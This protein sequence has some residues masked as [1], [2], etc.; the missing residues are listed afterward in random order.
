MRSPETSGKTS[1]YKSFAILLAQPFYNYHFDE[2]MDF[3]TV[4]NILQGAANGGFWVMMEN[5]EIM[6]LGMISLMS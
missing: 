3:L 6:D 5:L 2:K 1:I 4:A